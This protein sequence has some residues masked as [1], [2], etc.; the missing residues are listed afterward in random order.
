ME[1]WN[2]KGR[3]LFKRGKRNTLLKDYPKTIAS[4]QVQQEHKNDTFNFA[5]LE[6]SEI[7]GMFFEAIYKYLSFNKFQATL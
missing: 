3:L 5:K 2:S 6:F 4:Q 1:N 7:E